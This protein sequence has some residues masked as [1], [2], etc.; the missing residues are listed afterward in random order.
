VV[1][2]IEDKCHFHVNI[3]KIFVIKSMDWTDFDWDDFHATDPTNLNPWQFYIQHSWHRASRLFDEWGRDFQLFV[4]T[5]KTWKYRRMFYEKTYD[6]KTKK[7]TIQPNIRPML[8]TYLQDLSRRLFEFEKLLEM[9]KDNT[10]HSQDNFD[11]FAAGCRNHNIPV[12]IL[13]LIK[14][15]KELDKRID[16]MAF[17]K[18]GDRFVEEAVDGALSIALSWRHYHE[19]RMKDNKVGSMNPYTISLGARGPRNN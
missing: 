5:I 11:L 16:L 8:L 12:D 7:L 3:F 2:R 19:Q 18:Q 13:N 15:W 17:T 9:L 6:D 1:I 14:Q 4:A 10:P